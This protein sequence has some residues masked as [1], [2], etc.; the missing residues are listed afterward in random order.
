MY[1]LR[2]LVAATR[3]SQSSDNLLIA[4]FVAEI[5]DKLFIEIQFNEYI[6]QA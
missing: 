2:P 4:F 6:R 3:Q 5:K 1:D